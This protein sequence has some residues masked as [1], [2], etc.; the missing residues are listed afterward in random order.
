MDAA[1]AET[2]VDGVEGFG[3]ETQANWAYFVEESEDLE[4]G[5]SVL[6][7]QVGSE[8]VGRGERR[9]HTLLSTEW[10]LDIMPKQFRKAIIF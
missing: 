4:Y 1:C 5:I 2:G 3:G 7:I 6:Q 8:V 9:E 10:C